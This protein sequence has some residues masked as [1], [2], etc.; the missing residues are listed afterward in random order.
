MALHVLIVTMFGGA[1]LERYLL[2]V[3]PLLYISFAVAMSSLSERWRLAA[4]AA[5]FQLL[6]AANFINPIYPFPFEN[7]L[8]YVSFV[9][10]NQHAADFV[11]N[12]YPGG[13][14]VTTFPLAGALRRPDF[15]YVH[16]PLNVHEIDNFQ[17][18]SIVPLARNPPDA[19]IL[20]SVAWDPLALLSNGPVQNF[21]RDHY[22]YQPQMTGSDLART[23]HMH[24]VA[25]WTERGQWIEVFESDQLQPHS[26][27]AGLAAGK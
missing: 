27:R 24:S 7:N 3:L 16:H 2:P 1:V 22:G 19:L 21:L 13:V 6:I 11:E 8:A 18:S 26:L 5:L 17:A 20:Y 15:G 10:L 12:S 4:A 14:I 9:A 25:R 23:L